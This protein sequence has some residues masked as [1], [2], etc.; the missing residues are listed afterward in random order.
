MEVVQ[1]WS[2]LSGPEGTSRLHEEGAQCLQSSLLLHC[3]LSP[4]C[5]YGFPECSPQS[6]D[7]I[8]EDSGP[9]YRWFCM[10]CRYHPKVD[11]CSTAAPFW[12]TQRTMVKGN[13]PRGQNFKQCTWLFTLKREMP[14]NVIILIRGLW[15]VILAGWS[16][17]WKEHDWKTSHKEIWGRGRY[18]S[19]P[20]R[21]GKNKTKQ[22]HE[23]ICVPWECSPKGDHNTRGFQ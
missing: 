1:L 6:I 21:M 22:K 16:G 3:L 10:I 5:T 9:I 2:G 18:V 14:G 7:R 12:A 20:L 19:R 8:R 17:I 23:D 4:S 13:L 15:P 11:S